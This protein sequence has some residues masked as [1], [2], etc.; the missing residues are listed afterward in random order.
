MATA[1]AAPSSRRRDGRRRVESTVI[2][3]RLM[4]VTAPSLPRLGDETVCD[5][6]RL[7]AVVGGGQAFVA[8]GRDHVRIPQQTIALPPISINKT[9]R[10]RQFHVA[11]AVRSEL[12]FRR[13]GIPNMVRA[14]I[15]E[16]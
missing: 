4:G 5:R 13:T 11:H 9:D 15:P 6:G 12:L 16:R 1:A 14:G 7:I 8:P 2:G 10:E 3:P